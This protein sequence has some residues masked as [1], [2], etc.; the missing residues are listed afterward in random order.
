MGNWRT[1]NIVGRC[2]EKDVLK[3]KDVI[4][5][6]I[7]GDSEFYPLSHTKGICSLPMWA[8]KN[9]SVVGN[10]AERDYSLKSVAECLDELLLIAPSLDVVIHCGGDYE[11]MDCIATIKII[12]DK[13]TICD[14]EIDSLPE[15]TESQLMGHFYSQLLGN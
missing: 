8:L 12:D 4:S 10:L 11:S 6:D 1:V 13:S 7:S 15:I 2:D 3:L 5:W 14:P 9:I